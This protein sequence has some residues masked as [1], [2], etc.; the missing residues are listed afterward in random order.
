MQ[1]VFYSDV[2]SAVLRPSADV[3]CELALFGQGVAGA[4]DQKDLA[5]DLRE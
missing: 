4:G 1:Q 5:D 3:L 2:V